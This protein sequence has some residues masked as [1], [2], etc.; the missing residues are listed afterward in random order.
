MP[1]KPKAKVDVSGLEAFIEEGQLIEQANE[2]SSPIKPSENGTL[3]IALTDP[4]KETTTF[5]E[6]WRIDC[7]R[8]TD[9]EKGELA[10]VVAPWWLNREQFELMYDFIKDNGSPAAKAFQL[11]GVP[12]ETRIGKK[13]VIVYDDTTLAHVEGLDKLGKKA[14]AVEA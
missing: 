5:G 10:G 4:Y 1:S 9:P 11:T 14:L 7:E 8:I 12:V 6:K 3:F 2:N 13:D